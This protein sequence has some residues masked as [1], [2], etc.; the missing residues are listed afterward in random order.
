L[1][2]FFEKGDKPTEPQFVTLIDSQLQLLLDYGSSIDLH[3]FGLDVGGIGDDGGGAAVR[4]EAGSVIDSY[5][6]RIDDGLTVGGPSDWP[7]K[8]GFLGL[9]FELADAGGTGS[10]THYGF[11][12]LRVD[13]PSSST[14]YAV[15]VDAFA[16]ETVP[17]TPITMFSI[18]PEPSTAAL[19]GFGLL[20]IAQR[21]RERSPGRES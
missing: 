17:D 12:Q 4:F 2:T 9:I 16:Y 7:G 10:T 20:G 8:S 11:V 18:V 5:I 13:G 15:H 3:A 19:L 1:K 6:H 21:R 14:P